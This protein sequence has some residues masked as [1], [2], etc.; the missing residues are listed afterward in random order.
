MAKLQLCCHQQCSGCLCSFGGIWSVQ[1]VWS[2][3]ENSRQGGKRE[4]KAG[5]E[6]LAGHCQ[7]P[8][9]DAEIMSL[10]LSLKR[11][12]TSTRYRVVESP[13]PFEPQ[14][15]ERSTEHPQ[16]RAHFC[17]AICSHKSTYAPQHLGAL[18]GLLHS[19]L[20]PC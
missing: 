15:A 2:P 11:L 8:A 5:K 16:T 6:G 4:G 9:W 10:L 19:L 13:L 18:E 7:E 1:G 17:M 3:Q 14:Q 12:S 20:L